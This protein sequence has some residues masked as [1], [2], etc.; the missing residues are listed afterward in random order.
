MRGRILILL[1]GD[2]GDTLLTIPA[3][4]ALRLRY[5]DARIALL[6]KD[7]PARIVRPLDLVDEIIVVDKHLFD[8][9]RALRS[10]RSW[11]ALW[12]LWRRLRAFR[13][14][15]VVLYHHLVTRWG[16]A[17]FAALSLASGAG[18]RAGIDNGQGWFLTAAVRDEGFGARHEAEY[19]MAVS[20]LLDA[21]G[22]LQM[23]VAVADADRQ[24]AADVLP[25]GPLIAVHP[26]TGW[27]GPGR[28]WDARGFAEAA[29]RAAERLGAT[30]VVVGTEAER[31]QARAVLNDLGPRAVDLIG[32]T[33]VEQ[34]AAVLARC[35]VLIANDGGVA[36]LAAA[37]STPVVAVFGPSN[38]AAWRPLGGTVVAADLPCRPCF[39]R[40]FGRGLPHGCAQRE[41]LSLISPARVAEEA[42]ALAAGRR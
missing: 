19:F 27:Y 40:G 24:T 20:N 42:V 36:H 18:E 35:D 4:R 32:Q 11:P 37:V 16:T 15:T 21:D 1:F 13:A 38:D 14:D 41:C 28:R 31:G 9:P 34:L 12:R 39:Y 29:R 23:E 5:P 26:G 6:T 2:L 33:S 3:M 30:P 17:K 8:D 7:L 25:P 10:A 22:P